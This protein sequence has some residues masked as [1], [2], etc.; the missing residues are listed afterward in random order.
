MRTLSYMSEFELVVKAAGSQSQLAR[1]LNVTRQTVAS[2][3]HRGI[4]LQR[5]IEI[6]RVLGVPKE[7]IRPDIFR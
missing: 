7:T 5:A 1:A 2:W 3:R 6:E 4:P